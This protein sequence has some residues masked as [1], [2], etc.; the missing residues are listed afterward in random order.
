MQQ[1]I[2]RAAPDSAAARPAVTQVA[3]VIP[4][5]PAVVQ[6]LVT[7]LIIDATSLPDARVGGAAKRHGPGRGR[8]GPVD[9]D[10]AIRGLS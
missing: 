7:S 6:Q 2:D 10:C 8:T 4:V 3:A 5:R 9:D 1:T